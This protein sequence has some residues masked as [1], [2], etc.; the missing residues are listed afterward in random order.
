MR[1]SCTGLS[2]PPQQLLSYSSPVLAPIGSSKAEEFL[3]SSPAHAPKLAGSL[4]FLFTRSTSAKILYTNLINEERKGFSKGNLSERE[5]LAERLGSL[6]ARDLEVTN[7]GFLILHSSRVSQVFLA[8]AIS[9]GPRE[10]V[11]FA[12]DPKSNMHE[13][14]SPLS[15]PF[16]SLPSRTND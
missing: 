15:Q 3:H 12:A 10:K 2:L 16:H 6:F 5:F 4:F 11:Q 8:Y 7:F 9:T 14:V 1:G 13:R